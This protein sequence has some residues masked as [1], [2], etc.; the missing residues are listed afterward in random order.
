[1]VVLPRLSYKNGTILSHSVLPEVLPSRGFWGIGIG[2]AF[3]LQADGTTRRSV[4]IAPPH[5][6]LRMHE[7]V[8]PREYRLK[9]WSWV[10]TQ[11][12]PERAEHRIA[13]QIIR[14]VPVPTV[15]ACRA[16]LG[17][18]LSRPASGATIIMTIIFRHQDDA[19]P[20]HRYSVKGQTNTHTYTHEKLDG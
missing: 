2:L 17:L 11:Q 10:E 19:T 7:I 18:D 16:Q 6:T 9:W 1:M 13:G 12:H 3:T 8:R 20:V 5:Y 4:V 15:P 14:S